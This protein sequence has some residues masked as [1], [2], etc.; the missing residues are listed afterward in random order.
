MDLYLWI[1]FLFKIRHLCTR[2][3]SS[4]TFYSLYLHGYIAVQAN[5]LCLS[6][7]LCLYLCFLLAH[8]R[9]EKHCRFFCWLPSKAETRVRLS[10][11]ISLS[12][13]QWWNLVYI[14]S[15]RYVIW[16]LWATMA[17]GILSGATGFNV[18]FYCLRT[19]MTF[20]NGLAGLFII[21]RMD[22]ATLALTELSLCFNQVSHF[23]A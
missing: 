14:T 17:N 19:I 7:Y 23:S 2:V 9:S 20:L 1:V 3:S 6:L 18:S 16:S 15:F 5:P 22:M 10:C 12:F 8:F 13:E 4:Y 11:I 21:C